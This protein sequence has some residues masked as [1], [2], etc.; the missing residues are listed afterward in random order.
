MS[1]FSINNIF[2]NLI[3]G[4]SQKLISKTKQLI[5]QNLSQRSFN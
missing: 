3:D 1:H 4:E 5:E 2:D